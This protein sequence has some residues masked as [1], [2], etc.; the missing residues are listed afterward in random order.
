MTI[1][2]TNIF[3]DYRSKSIGR[4]FIKIISKK[5]FLQRIQRKFITL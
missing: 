5:K 1:S 4:D 3:D 2:K